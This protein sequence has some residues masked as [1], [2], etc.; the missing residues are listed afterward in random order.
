MRLCP[1]G[2]LKEAHDD[3][4][5][6]PLVSLFSSHP[7]LMQFLSVIGFLAVEE[8]SAGSFHV[9]GA[10]M[11]CGGILVLGASLTY[12]KTDVLAVQKFDLYESLLHSLISY[13]EVVFTLLTWLCLVFHRHQI[14]AFLTALGRTFKPSSLACRIVFLATA[15]SYVT[16]VSL[17]LYIERAN[18]AYSINVIFVSFM[19]PSALDLAFVKVLNGVGMSYSRV[20][21]SLST[22]THPPKSCLFG[23]SSVH[24]GCEV[25]DNDSDH[26]GT[27]S[28]SDLREHCDHLADLIHLQNKAISFVVMCRVMR[29]LARSLVLGY[30]SLMTLGSPLPVVPILYITDETLRFYAICCSADCLK[31]KHQDLEDAVWVLQH[32]PFTPTAHRPHLDALALRLAARPAHLPLWSG[33]LGRAAFVTCINIIFTYAALLMQYRP[34]VYQNRANGTLSQGSLHAAARCRVFSPARELASFPGKL[35]QLA[36][37]ARVLLCTV[38]HKSVQPQ[39]PQ[40]NLTQV[41]K[42]YGRY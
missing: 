10:K 20:L 12:V 14:C 3:S 30:H 1:G 40:V 26:T 13:I 36:R 24:C 41:K 31:K 35:I 22:P 2:P 21:A 17:Q 39:V 42:I 34:I 15:A 19:V 4:E 33:V 5:D 32:H 28:V 16:F 7:D 27:L 18:L 25:R 11:V 8:D 38:G 23:V 37:M 6:R 29:F 9:H